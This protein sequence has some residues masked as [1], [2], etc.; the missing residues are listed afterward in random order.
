MIIHAVIAGLGVPV[1]RKNTWTGI[2]DSTA[3]C[4][5]CNFN[6]QARNATGTAAKHADA[7]ED[8]TVHVE[9]V[10]SITYNKKDE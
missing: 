4:D 10:T 2:L 1:P 7:H 6:L 3:W 5:D 8:H 9:Q